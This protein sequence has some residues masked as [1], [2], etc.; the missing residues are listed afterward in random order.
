MQLMGPALGKPLALALLLDAVV[1]HGTVGHAG[2]V[3]RPIGARKW[4]GA[5][6]QDCALDD[7]TVRQ[8]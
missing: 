7:C 5:A 1:P 8:H 2:A 6:C 3:G 4:T